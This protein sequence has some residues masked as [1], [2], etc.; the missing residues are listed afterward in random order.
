MGRRPGPAGRRHC[1]GIYPDELRRI[2]YEAVVRTQP[3]VNFSDSLEIRYGCRGAERGVI[4][5]SMI[6]TKCSYP[7]LIFR[8]TDRLPIVER[9]KF[10]GIHLITNHIAHGWSAEE[11]A[12]NFPQL[13]LGEIYSVLSWFSDHREEVENLVERK[14]ADAKALRLEARHRQI[15]KRLREGGILESSDSTV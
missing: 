11:L 8:E 2:V 3:E 12:I 14:A 6:E 9:V 7:H 1:S 5:L 15:A 10:K 4:F 13:T